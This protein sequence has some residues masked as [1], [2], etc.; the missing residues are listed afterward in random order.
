MSDPIPDDIR[1]LVQNCIDGVAD[2]EAL[3]TLARDRE[4][5]WSPEQIANRLYLNG[6]EA[7]QVLARLAGHG[8]A[9]RTEAGYRY[10]RL[11][12][13]DAAKVDRLLGLYATHLIPITRLIHGKRVG[14]IQQFA[15]AFKLRKKE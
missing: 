1:E 6:D 13:A 5:A 15:E 10:A 8:L 7:E 12:E 3:V 4:R 14:R 9:E 2:M 11:H